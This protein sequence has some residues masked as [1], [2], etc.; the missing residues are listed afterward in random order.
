MSTVA[1]KHS[2]V[3][4]AYK[5]SPYLETCI[6]SLLNQTVH[7]EI[8]IAT[9]TPSVFLQQIASRYQLRLS[10]NPEQKGIAA[11]WNYACRC[12]HAVCHFSPSR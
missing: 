11:D 3:V 5:E 8:V 1:A 4:L 10:V 6:Q 12:Y 9:S 7:S 2:F